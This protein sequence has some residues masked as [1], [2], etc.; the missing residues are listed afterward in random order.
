MDAMVLAA[1]AKWPN[2]PAVYGWLRLDA[3]GQWWLDGTRVEHA[4]LLDFLQRN[5]ARDGQGRYYV[6]NG[7]QKVY[8]ELEAAPFVARHAPVGWTLT[9]PCEEAVPRAAFLSDDG[10]LYLEMAGELA[11]L[12]DRDWTTLAECLI[13]ERGQP[14][15]EG[16]LAAFLAGEGELALQL[17]EGDLALDR[18]EFAALIARYGIDRSPCPPDGACV[19]TP[20]GGGR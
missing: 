3:R 11:R 5:Y 6:Q 18:A 14:A 16:A 4:G 17:P 7:P 13:D 2:V 19:P 10:D 1:M 15:G 9:P 8:V 20:G 12:D